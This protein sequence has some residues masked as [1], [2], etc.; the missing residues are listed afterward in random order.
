[1]INKCQ[2]ILSSGPVLTIPFFRILIPWISTWL[3]YSP[4]SGLYMNVTFLVRT[5]QDTLLKMANLATCQM[6]FHFPFW[7]FYLTFIT[8]QLITSFIRLSGFF[9]VFHMRIWDKGKQGPFFVRKA[10]SFMILSWPTFPDAPISKTLL[11]F[12]IPVTYFWKS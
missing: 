10:G 7:S 12:F 8:V 6:F 11:T 4:S 3:F 9:L 1:M 2:F 5:T